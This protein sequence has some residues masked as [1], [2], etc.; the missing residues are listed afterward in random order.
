MKKR[1]IIISLIFIIFI[2]EILA[3]SSFVNVNCNN[4][5]L[6]GNSFQPL[7][8][9]Y[10]IRFTKDY[11]NNNF[12]L[13]PDW[14]Y[15]TYPNWGSPSDVGGP[16][17]FFFSQTNDKGVSLTKVQQ[18]MAK[19]KSLG[20]NTIRIDIAP[21]N[22][23]GILEIPTGSYES[24][25][26]IVDQLLGFIN[27]QNLK[28]IFLVGPDKGWEVH[29]SFKSYLEIIS[30]HFKN[31]T[32][33]LGYDLCNEPFR[34]FYNN[35][36]NDKYKI[37]NWVTEWCY[38]I[39]KND[40]NHLITIGL[41]DSD[42]TINW[43]PLIMPIDFVS[44][45]FY[46]RSENLQTSKERISSDIYW[47]A[48]TIKMPWIIGEIGFSG[49]NLNVDDPNLVVGSENDQANFAIYSMQKS[50]DC[51]CKGYTWWQYQNIMMNDPWENNLGL[52]NFYGINGFTDE[53]NKQAANVISSFWNMSSNTNNCTKPSNYYNRY[54][55]TSIDKTGRVIGNNG[56]PVENAVIMGW[57]QIGTTYAYYSTYS[58]AN[59]YFTLRSN[60]PGYSIYTMWISFPGYSVVKVNNP[61][62]G[63]TYSI[64]PINYNKWTKKWTNDGSNTIG[65]WSIH[66]YDK[67]YKGDFNGDGKDEMLCTSFTGGNGDL[68]TMFNY[69]N[70]TSEWEKLWS[71]NGNSTLGDGIYTYRNNFTIGDF[72]GDG[73][74]DLLGID[75]N[76]YWLTTFTFGI[77]GQWHWWQ[78]NNGYSNNPIYPMSYLTPYAD[79]IVSGDFDADGRDE[80]IGSELPNGWTTMFKFTT[81]NKWSWQQSDNGFLN[82]PSY[83]MS[84]MRQYRDQFIVGDFDADGKDDILGNDLPN[85]YITLFGFQNGNWFSK[86]SDNGIDIIGMRPYRNNFIV[87]NFDNDNKDE[88][89]G[90]STWATKFDFE[91][92]N[93]AWD[94]STGNSSLFSDWA[95]LPTAK[96]YFFF[97]T[98][99]NSPEQLISFRKT[100]NNYLVNRYSYNSEYECPA[101]LK[102]NY[103]NNSLS[104][105]QINNDLDKSEVS[106]Y[107]NPSEGKFQISTNNFNISELEII[108]IT[109]KII[110][111]S[112][113]ENEN[114]NNFHLDISNQPNGIYFVILTNSKNTTFVNKV[115]LNK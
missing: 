84:F 45:H 71:N 26:T 91:S 39:K 37:S 52:I 107:P 82:N 36:V 92:N 57:K 23:N 9:C 11:I 87:G 73:R 56:L 13:S 95:I 106:I 66:D 68:I 113:I 47:A 10:R 18:D 78:S 110:S 38:A 2:T 21:V 1:K 35:N 46:G 12:Y 105:S 100:G 80:L 19:I 90:F 58:D 17:R 25:F 24:Y 97:K 85:G 33:I 99:K 89:L 49:S 43:D 40:Q 54:N 81:A 75:I 70:T 94:W 76:G 6:N 96:K 7:V 74:D 62:S 44:F 42:N 101:T 34:F 111:K 48:K 103:P 20:F 50:L 115:I 77:D 53:T 88:I 104:E 27:T 108:D 112:K 55:Y 22:N 59:G 102:L 5:E 72:N 98:N 15:S 60:T 8:C 31:N 93:F 29:E 86:W 79:Y 109:G 83:P 3:Q 51:K 63:S 28:V 114:E 64:K 32:S 69:N 30:S 14:N 61:N 65:D 67:F 16:G 4:F 41:T